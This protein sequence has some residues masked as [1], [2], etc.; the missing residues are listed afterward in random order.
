[1]H[2]LFFSACKK[3]QLQQQ[4]KRQRPLPL[5]LQTWFARIGL[6]AAG[7]CS[8][9]RL[10]PPP[11]AAPRQQLGVSEHAPAGSADGDEA[12][13]HD[14]TTYCW[15]NRNKVHGNNKRGTCHAFTVICKGTVK[16]C[17]WC[18]A[19]VAYEDDAS[20]CQACCD[21]DDELA[22]FVQRLQQVDTETP[23]FYRSMTLPGPGRKYRQWTPRPPQME[24]GASE[25][26]HPDAAMAVG[27]VQSALVASDL[28]RRVNTL[29]AELVRRGQ[30]EADLIR[31]V[32][33]LEASV[34]AWR[35]ALQSTPV[36]WTS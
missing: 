24:R 20:L 30:V 16:H 28:Q 2:H 4:Q 21:E 12:D 22:D 27:A 36:S 32:E 9:A 6:G 23:T 5:R 17:K 10:R 15:T 29:E 31:R 19:L 7:L 25:H 34:G 26:T 13:K 33:A 8:R 11:M 18:L 14:H 1:M 35:A 3:K